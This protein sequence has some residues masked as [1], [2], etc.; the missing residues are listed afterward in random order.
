MENLKSNPIDTNSSL[1]NQVGNKE[2]LS[3]SVYQV[4]KFVTNI[5]NNPLLDRKTVEFRDRAREKLIEFFKRSDIKLEGIIA[6]PY[7]SMLWDI[8]DKSDADFKLVLEKGISLANM[9]IDFL[10]EN[11]L[12]ISSP[13]PTPLYLID[14]H[15]IATL[16][17]LIITPDAYLVGNI[18]LAREIRKTAL[19]NIKEKYI[20]PD[21]AQEIMN[22][23]FEIFYKNWKDLD[24]TR[25]VTAK[26]SSR[27]RQPR[28]ERKLDQ[29][30]NQT[31]T[32]QKWKGAYKRALDNMHLPDMQT[33]IDCFNETNGQLL[34]LP[35][36]HKGI[37]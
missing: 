24:H 2:R 16:L 19:N 30:A 7:G 10:G 13:I 4:R 14:G 3:S 1:L 21:F 18:K 23:E 11:N 34:E 31:Y 36:Q 26:E 6:I 8:D 15:D 32:P 37:I 29:R 22:A 27:A 17:N 35:N 33:L 9:D 5:W 28:F 20:L 25:T 12:S